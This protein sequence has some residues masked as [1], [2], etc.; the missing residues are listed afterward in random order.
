MFC[1]DPKRKPPELGSF[2]H[3]LRIVIHDEERRAT[4]PLIAAFLK[5]VSIWPGS[6]WLLQPAGLHAALRAL[7]A[8]YR[9][10]AAHT[11]ELGKTDYA[12]C[13]NHVIGPD[14]ALW[15]LVVATDARA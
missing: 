4:S 9:N 10:P 13:R 14:G 7:T 2:A 8:K 15:K 3:F 1:A 5:L 6:Q 11:D 12:A